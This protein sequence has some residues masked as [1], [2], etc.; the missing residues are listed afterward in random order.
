M[1][2]EFI[3]EI[4]H[5]SWVSPIVVVPKKNGKLRLC[6]NLKKVN[7]ATIRDNYPL[8]IAEHVLERVAGKKAFSFLDGSLDIIRFPLILGINTKPHLLLNGAYTLT[9]NLLTLLLVNIK[10]QRSFYLPYF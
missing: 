3:Y 7:A 1:E 9:S 6:V 4:E 10:I 2:A 5:T 8:P